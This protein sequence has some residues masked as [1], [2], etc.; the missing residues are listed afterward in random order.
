MG[1][2]GRVRVRVEIVHA[3]SGAITG[4]LFNAR[5]VAGSDLTDDGNLRAVS[6]SL[7]D[8]IASQTGAVAERSSLMSVRPEHNVSM[9]N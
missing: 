5:F 6:R 3:L 9:S 8:S 7:D 4:T 1:S 2:L